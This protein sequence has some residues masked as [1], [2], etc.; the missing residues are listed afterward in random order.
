MYMGQ[1]THDSSEDG[2]HEPGGTLIHPVNLMA[3]A[4]KSNI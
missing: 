1:K 2:E 3:E 4:E